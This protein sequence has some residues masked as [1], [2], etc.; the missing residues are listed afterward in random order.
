[1]TRRRRRGYSDDELWAA[2]HG[3][4]RRRGDLPPLT[5]EDVARAERRPCARVPRPLREAPPAPVKDEELRPPD[6]LVR[7]WDPGAAELPMARAARQGGTVPP[8][9]E[10]I[11][12]RDRERAEAEFDAGREDARDG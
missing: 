4:L 6:G 3:A 1:M 7:L 8:G 5:D 12:R 2:V 11:M 10:R 9:I